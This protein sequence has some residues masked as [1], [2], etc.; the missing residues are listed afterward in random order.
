MNEDL[1]T[2]IKYATV[3]KCR[4]PGMRIGPALM[5]K[6]NEIDPKAYSLISESDIDPYYSDEKLDEFIDF[7]TAYS[8]N[9]ITY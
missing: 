2:Y 4:L 1:L 3:L 6:L 7:L 5:G 8:Q 9:E